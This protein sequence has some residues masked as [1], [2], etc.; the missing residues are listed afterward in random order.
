[1]KGLFFQKEGDANCMYIKLYPDSEICIATDLNQVMCSSDNFFLADCIHDGLDT[2][3]RVFLS[4]FDRTYV[5]VPTD[6]YKEFTFKE[7]NFEMYTF[8]K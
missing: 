7:T 3:K 5:I 8:S 2:N 6:R 4:P 1:M